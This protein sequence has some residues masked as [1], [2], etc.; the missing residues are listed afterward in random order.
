MGGT[1]E[2]ALRE[3]V[4]ELEAKL[5]DAQAGALGDAQDQLRAN[6]Q[7][8]RAIFDGAMDA[9]LIA[10]D[11]GRY[12][13]VNP[14]AC[15][16]FGLAKNELLGRTAAE[17]AAPG[18]EPVAEWKAFVA[19]GQMRGEFPLLRADGARRD[20]EFLAVAHVL[21]GRHLSVL[22]DVTERLANEAALR[23]SQ[24][25]LEE[26]QAVAHVGSWTSGSTPTEPVTWSAECARI[27][28]VAAS[29]APTTDAFFEW[30]HVD[31]RPAVI[32]AVRT[33]ATQGV[34]ME[35][36]H[37]IVL[38]TGEVRW[39]FTRTVVKGV[40][41]ADGESTGYRS[42]FE[43]GY[44]VIGIV[45][46][47]TER[48]RVGDELRASEQRYR[49]IVENTSQG[50]WMYDA[51]NTTTFV[52]SRMAAMLGY[53]VAEVMGRTVL[54]FMHAE[55]RQEARERIA[56]RQAGV[57][58]GGESRLVRRDGSD[59]WVEVQ[60][61]PLLDAMG[62]FESSL[63]LL[64][65]ITDRRRADDTRNRL[66]AIVESSNDAILSMTL[67]GV[68]T[69][70]NHGARKLFGYEASEIVGTSVLSLVPEDREPEEADILASIGRAEPVSHYETLRRRKDGTM[71]DVALTV[72]PIFDRRG[73][74]V[75]VSKVVRDISEGRKAV[76][77]LRRSEEQLRQAQKMEAVGNLAGGVAHDFNNLLSVILSYA[78]LMR[79]DLKPAD[80]MRADI[81]E[82][83][84]ASARATELTRQLLA[85]SRKQILQPIVVDL[86]RIVTDVRKM[87]GRLI[88]EDITLS[89][90]PSLTACTVDADPG[91][92]EQVIMNL[93]VNARD[94]MPTG[95]NLTIET[96]C[97][98]LDAE[99]AQAHVGV[100]PG[101]YVMIAVTDTG[102]GM[103]AATQARVFEPFFTTKDKSKGTGLGLSTVYGIVQQ[104]RGHV[105]VYSEVGTGT[106][107]KVYL[108]RTDRT[109]ESQAPA[110]A[111]SGV[112]RGHE[113][114]LLVEDDDQL[115]NILRSVLRKN[116]Y[117]VL[118]AQ[119]GG[120]AFLICEQFKARVDLL[121]T[122]VVMPRM[123]GRQLAER[124][125]QLR[126]DLLVLYMSGYTED[127]IV[128][129]GVLDAGIDFLPKPVTPDL[130]L[131]KVRAVI[132]GRSGRK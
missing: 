128:H 88:G 49:R 61:T 35:T 37:R 21:P 87:L 111:L 95:G 11:A 7:L 19:D 43:V 10:D 129:H 125:V 89:V 48:R 103:D 17:F 80:P 94:A 57:E 8:L 30:I 84:K 130:L 23:E 67:E 102:T 92:I 55:Y 18:Y 9:M 33:A 104:S 86:N 131:R 74:V 70:W 66:A 65:D 119:N 2:Q 41:P 73:A 63:A 124:L 38:A 13:D 78:T 4:A 1:G 12:V 77:A 72:S 15:S 105:W 53:S 51:T 20:L 58:E 64:T 36:E 93:A 121:L 60:A 50:I 83:L 76:T 56:R 27:F 54:D 108:P 82:I 47:V 117:H 68:I 101:E 69:T 115:R 40:I 85:F 34:P 126:P 25:V 98:T 109:P 91:Q 71:V 116:G 113:T 59:L 45:Q 97:V 112:L 14:A 132:D 44:R 90:L 122:D 29:A 24:R 99:Y 120:E 16:L 106:T 100:E 123:S 5:A 39:V 42:G 81:E 79:E 118:E 110:A 52:N 31:D 32:A 46:D 75:A 62:R 107:F 6:E 127:T 96:A 114:I 3:R 28:G 26:A 22:R